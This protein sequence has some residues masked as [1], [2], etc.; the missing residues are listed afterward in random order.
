MVESERDFK[1]AFFFGNRHYSEEQVI[2][3]ANALP[4]LI[5][6][7]KKTE[8]ELDLFN[9]ETALIALHTLE[10]L[11][12]KK[13]FDL[14]KHTVATDI[15]ENVIRW[16]GRTQ[17]KGWDK[18]VL[19]MLELNEYVIRYSA[20]CGQAARYDRLLQEG[21]GEQA[22]SEI[23]RLLNSKHIDEQEMGSYAV[24]EIAKSKIQT[25]ITPHI[26]QWLEKV[27]DT[28][29]YFCQSVLGDVLLDLVLQNQD[30]EHTKR[31]IEKLDQSHLISAF[32]DPIWMYTR[33]D[34]IA[35]LALLKEQGQQLSRDTESF[36]VAVGLEVATTRARQERI[37][38]FEKEAGGNGKNLTKILHK[39]EFSDEDIDYI[40]QWLLRSEVT[41]GQR[42]ST[43][44]EFL[45]LIFTH[46]LWQICEKG[47]AILPLIGSEL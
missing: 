32:W 3:I 10:D 47:A 23:N 5:A 37:T 18:L 33:L 15:T 31:I 24:G 9:E 2:I 27:S 8:S 25:E 4:L 22:V 42:I 38:K 43:A 20:G 39:T 30:V 17:L 44:V 6:S 35:V 34:V 7:L 41:R 46:P 28:D 13:L 11:N 1:T 16:I 26:K 21:N 19:Q 12:Q 14:V 45:K 29:I 36:Q 40:K